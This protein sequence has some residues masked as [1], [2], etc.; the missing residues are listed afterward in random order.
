LKILPLLRSFVGSVW[1]GKIGVV[2]RVAGGF[3][4]V[5]G[6]G[7]VEVVSVGGG[8]G[9]HRAEEREVL[10]P[11]WGSGREVEQSWWETQPTS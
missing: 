9:G 6:V 7:V 11:R 1:V 10:L 3:A 8:V 5:G 2:G 4:C